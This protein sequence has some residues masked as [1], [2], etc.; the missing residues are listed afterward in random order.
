MAYLFSGGGASTWT[1]TLHLVRT[2]VNYII[3]HPQMYAKAK[4]QDGFDVHG[5]WNA[6]EG[7]VR[8]QGQA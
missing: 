2:W 7:C 1:S 3:D 6:V 8:G 4:K 5:I